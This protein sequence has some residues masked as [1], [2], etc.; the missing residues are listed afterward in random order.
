MQES[1]KKELQFYTNASI[2]KMDIHHANEITSRKHAEMTNNF[3]IGQ[4]IRKSTRIPKISIEMK[5]KTNRHIYLHL[6]AMWSK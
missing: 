5:E 6:E 1:P 3:V 4:P 2:A